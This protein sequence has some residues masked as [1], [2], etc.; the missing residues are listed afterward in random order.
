MTR[1]APLRA[2]PSSK[3]CWTLRRAGDVLVVWRLDRLGR[4]V[5]NLVSA[6]AALGEWGVELR[7]LTE[8]IDTTTANGRLAFH[9]FAAVTEFE[10]DLIRARMNAGLAAAQGRGRVG[11]RQAE[12]TEEKRAAAD[13][14]LALPGATVTAVARALGSPGRRSTGTS[15][16][17]DQQER[18]ESPGETGVSRREH[19]PG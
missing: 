7:S 9:I 4:S 18:S 3:L 16:S 5:Q 12:T 8:R 13:E 11:G 14:L 6:V 1:A 17:A 2:G 15:T 19:V 10:A